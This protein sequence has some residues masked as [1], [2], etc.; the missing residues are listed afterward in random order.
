M[1]VRSRT[2]STRSERPQSVTWRS[3]SIGARYSRRS[4]SRAATSRPGPALGSSVSAR[5][6]SRSGVTA[7]GS[8]WRSVLRVASAMGTES[9]RRRVLRDAGLAR[10][11]Q[12]LELARQR[13]PV[14]RADD[15][16]GLAHV[17]VPRMHERRRPDAVL[18]RALQVGRAVVD[19][20]VD[21]DLVA[22]GDLVE[23]AVQLVE[24]QPD[25]AQP[26]LGGR[27]RGGR[28]MAGD[29][30]EVA[31]LGPAVDGLDGARVGAAGEDHLVAV[32]LLDAAGQLLVPQARDPPGQLLLVRQL[33]PEAAAGGG[34]EDV[35]V[36][37]EGRIDVDGD[38]HGAAGTASPRPVS[39]YRRAMA[40]TV[41]PRRE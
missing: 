38:A 3:G 30:D 36:V 16:L 6:S 34:R 20:Q 10:G 19:E 4:G 18:D 37:V 24:A 31:R 15:V 8:T 35:P 14:A 32:G 26:L 7:A 17:L 5:A 33:D 28:A 13:G 9:P 25:L 2:P 1:S 12:R 27:V 39:S 21:A 40:T 11:H 41:A 23:R 22:A 29:V